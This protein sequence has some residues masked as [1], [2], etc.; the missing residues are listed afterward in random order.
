MNPK[1]PT[2]SLLF[3]K[4]IHFAFAFVF[5]IATASPASAAARLADL[6]DEKAPVVIMLSDVP[7]II[8]QWGQCPVGQIFN[9]PGMREFL[10]SVHRTEA[11]ADAGTK[12]NDMPLEQLALFA[13]ANVRNILFALTSASP[14]FVNDPASSSILLVDF[15]SSANPTAVEQFIEKIMKEDS[16]AEYRTEEYHKTVIH[17]GTSVSGANGKKITAYWA[18]SDGVFLVSGN[19]ASV[20]EAIDRQRQHAP[21]GTFGLSV[22]YTR[23]QQTAGVTH[24]LITVDCQQLIGCIKALAADE[25]KND[26]MAAMIDLATID[27]L[28]GLDAVNDLFCGVTLDGS[29][30][31]IAGA[32]TYSERRGLLK[33]LSPAPASAALP[34]Q[35]FIPESWSGFTITSFNGEEA[36][37]ALEDM[38]Q[39]ASPF[40]AAMISEQ[41]NSVNQRVGVDLRKDVI[42]NI[43][44]YLVTGQRQPSPQSRDFNTFVALPLKS[45]ETFAQSLGKVIAA[46]GLRDT[47]RS[48]GNLSVHTISNGRGGPGG[49]FEYVIARDQFFACGGVGGVEQAVRC[50]AGQSEN[51]WKDA[52]LKAIM[53]DPMAGMCGI[54]R[55][56]MRSTARTALYPLMLALRRASVMRRAEA[57][58]QPASRDVSVNFTPDMV[59]PLDS[60]A[61]FN[62]YS[63]LYHK[64]DGLYFRTNVL[65]K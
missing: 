38:L 57:A 65:K 41:I 56:N 48:L 24:A 47:V 6:I 23:V 55:S 18:F 51:V 33:I 62:A 42:G 64:D 12:N 10:S 30:M 16:L 40:A 22:R 34:R 32:C 1:K 11:K 54:S 4:P 25:M 8:R 31:Q 14:D 3:F 35:P 20:T 37:A 58:G 45:P 26:G 19:R 63:Y 13:A 21:L 53:D 9:D 52:S 17:S 60:L 50:W 2:P 5:A 44:G 39:G 36:L 28:A 61:P 27:K 46:M 15:Q 29:S 49:S 59:P 43:N 7:G